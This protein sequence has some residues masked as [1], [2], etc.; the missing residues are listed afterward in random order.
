MLQSNKKQKFCSYCG[1]PVSKAG[2]TCGDKACII[3]ARKETCMKIYGVDNPYKSP[4]IQEK[5]K[6]TNRLK[7][8]KDYYYQTNEFKNKVKKTNKERYGV[9]NVAKLEIVKHHISETCLEK[10]GVSSYSQTDEFKNNYKKNIDKFL[11]K[12]YQTKKKN[13]SFNKSKSEDKLY[14][15]K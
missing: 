5:I 6:E 2:R 13:N 8:N 14:K 10:Y 4:L 11:E 1:K 15:K 12:Q 3:Q 9:D 7:Y